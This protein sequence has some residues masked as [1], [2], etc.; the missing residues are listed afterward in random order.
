MLRAQALH[1]S[2]TGSQTAGSIAASQAAPHRMQAETPRAGTLLPRVRPVTA[3]ADQTAQ[4]GVQ[5]QLLPAVQD[6]SIQ[7]QAAGQPRV[8]MIAPAASETGV[9]TM[10]SPPVQH[11]SIHSQPA[12]QQHVQPSTGPPSAPGSPAPDTRVSMA[13][14]VGAQAKPS[15]AVRDQHSQAQTGAAAAEAATQASFA[16]GFDGQ[17]AIGTQVAQ[18]GP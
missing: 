17:V 15:P 14:S 4:A 9:Q 8:Q 7:V 3:A 6:A 1:R 10:L 5:T 2:E 18:V 16:A 13:R 11:L 12:A